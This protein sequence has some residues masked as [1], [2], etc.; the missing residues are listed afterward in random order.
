[1]QTLG[2]QICFWGLVIA[3]AVVLIIVLGAGWASGGAERQAER[4]ENEKG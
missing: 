3:L 2:G 4:T 1:M